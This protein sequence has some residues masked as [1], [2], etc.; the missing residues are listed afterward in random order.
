MARGETGSPLLL[1]HPEPEEGGQLCL[2]A[3]VGGAWG[4]E[5]AHTGSPPSRVSPRPGEAPQASTNPSP[6]AGQTDVMRVGVG[7]RGAAW[8]AG[9]RYASRSAPWRIIPA[10]VRVEHTLSPISS[11]LALLKQPWKNGAY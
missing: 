4:E 1:K 8:P 11:S 2:W 5:T 3:C 10:K 6:E 7:L 9:A